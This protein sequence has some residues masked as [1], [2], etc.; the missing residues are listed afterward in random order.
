MFLSAAHIE[1]DIDEALAATDA[2]LREVAR[3][4]G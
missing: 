2:A 4:F 3:R 1:A